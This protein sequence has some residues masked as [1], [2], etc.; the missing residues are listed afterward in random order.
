MVFC[1]SSADRETEIG[2]RKLESW[3]FG[4]FEDC[5]FCFLT[6]YMI[7]MILL[8]YMPFCVSCF[9]C[10]DRESEIG[11]GKLESW[12]LGNVEGC[13]LFLAFSMIWMIPL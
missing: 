4:N 5:C 12:K 3:T 9:C 8:D 2:D 13:I 6:I 1:C 11:D 7:L 10:A